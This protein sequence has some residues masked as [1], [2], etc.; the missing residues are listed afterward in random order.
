MH[1]TNDDHH[2]YGGI[3]NESDFY[4][5]GVIV[6]GEKINRIAKELRNN[7]KLVAFSHPYKRSFN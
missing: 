3:I 1:M 4:T 5:N 2:M 6:P 7:H